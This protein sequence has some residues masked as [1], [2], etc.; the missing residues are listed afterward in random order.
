M[1]KLAQ[2]KSLCI[3]KEELQPQEASVHAFQPPSPQMV[4]SFGIRTSP[5]RTNYPSNPNSP[6]RNAGNEIISIV[7]FICF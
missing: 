3:S 6:A 2:R 4:D 1:K 5:Q 7:S